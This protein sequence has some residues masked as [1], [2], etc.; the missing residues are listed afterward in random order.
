MMG[1]KGMAFDDLG[2]GPSFEWSGLDLRKPL[3]IPFACC[4][5]HSRL[6][7]S[8]FKLGGYTPTKLPSFN[9]PVVASRF[10]IWC[11]R[12]VKSCSLTLCQPVMARCRCPPPRRNH[13]YVNRTYRDAPSCKSDHWEE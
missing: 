5:V 11:A 10:T 3:K 12:E 6:G 2:H 7:F 8:G 13:G 1:S 4:A 9:L